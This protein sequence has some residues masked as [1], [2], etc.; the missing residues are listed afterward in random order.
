MWS[1]V[2]FRKIVWDAEQCRLKSFWILWVQS[3]MWCFWMSPFTQNA[4]PCV[5]S[6]GGGWAPPGRVCGIKR[7]GLRKESLRSQQHWR[8][9]ER[10]TLGGFLSLLQ[11]TDFIKGVWFCHCKLHLK[12]FILKALFLIDPLLFL[13]S[14]IESWTFLRCTHNKYLGRTIAIT[15]LYQRKISTFSFERKIR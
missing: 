4:L 11:V 1:A 3:Y 6:H 7:K 8:L 2:Y 15:C 5:W 9:G 10:K 14:N 12:M 13:I